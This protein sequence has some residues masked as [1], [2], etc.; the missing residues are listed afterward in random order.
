MPKQYADFA[1]WAAEKM[2]LEREVG[3]AEERRG[4]PSL[5]PLLPVAFTPLPSL[6]TPSPLLTHSSPYP[7]LFILFPVSV[8]FCSRHPGRLLRR[9]R[10]RMR[11]RQPL[12]PRPSA[13]P[14]PPLVAGPLTSVCTMTPWPCCTALRMARVPCLPWGA[15]TMTGT[16]SSWPWPTPRLTSRTSTPS[17]T[18][19]CQRT[20]SALWST[21]LCSTPRRT[22]ALTR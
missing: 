19:R 21:C 11:L 5:L 1:E 2:D 8:S 22:M 14:M 9:R 6:V 3:S 7:H 17:T 13:R 12:L 16:M 4:A 10:R 20:R 15:R 18:W